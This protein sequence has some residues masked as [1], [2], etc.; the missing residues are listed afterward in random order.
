MPTPI[1]DLHIAGEEL[2]PTPSEL[3]AAVPAGEAQ[4]AAI[5]RSR[6]LVRDIVHGR[7]DR[8]M[9]VTGPCSIHDIEA[10][11]E[12][13]GRLRQTAP[14]VDDALLLVMRVYFEKPRTRMK[15]AAFSTS[16]RRLV[17]MR[18]RV[19]SSARTS[20]LP[21]SRPPGSCGPRLPALRRPFPAP[22]QGIPGPQRA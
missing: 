7:D 10:A 16:L 14:R 20:S 9:V 12:Y 19:A 6:G 2:L 4:Q 3:R 8:L 1:A 18:W 21:W 11:R 5:A 15:G 22:P 17:V 13:A